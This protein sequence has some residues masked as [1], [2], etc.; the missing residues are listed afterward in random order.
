LDY[1]ERNGCVIVTKDEDFPNLALNRPGPAVLWVRI[2]N[3]VNP[4][5]FARFEA[6][7]PQILALLE[8]GARIVGLR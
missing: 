4:V 1:A 2:G 7:W 5:L 6:E 3:T 8:S